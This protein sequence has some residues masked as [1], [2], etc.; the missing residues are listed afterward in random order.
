MLSVDIKNILKKQIQQVMANIFR[1]NNPGSGSNKS[2]TES[3][4]V[5]KENFFITQD[6]EQPKLRLKP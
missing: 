5:T 2:D 6:G 1:L 4:S 3:P